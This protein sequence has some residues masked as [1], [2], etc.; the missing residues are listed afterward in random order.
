MAENEDKKVDN[1]A[2]GKA[3]S[4]Q[5]IVMRLR[6]AANNSVLEIGD[7]RNLLDEAADAIEVAEKLCKVYFEIAELQM[8]PDEIRAIR[9]KKFGA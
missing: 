4:V 9:R 5:R 3:V 1:T 2:N 8:N 7:A 6:D